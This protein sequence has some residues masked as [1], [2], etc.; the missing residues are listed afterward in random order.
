LQDGHFLLT[1]RI[2]SFTT[3]NLIQSPTTDY[4]DL[5]VGAYIGFTFNIGKCIILYSRNIH[6]CGGL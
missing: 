2:F 6:A 5:I 1:L 3:F 4:Q